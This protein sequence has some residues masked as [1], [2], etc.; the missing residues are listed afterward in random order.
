MQPEPTRTHTTPTPP[1]HR[2]H[3]E[4]HLAVRHRER[5]ESVHRAERDARA[6]RA[7]ADV[8]PDRHRDDRRSDARAD[9]VRVAHLRGAADVEAGPLLVAAG[10]R[11]IVTGGR[12]DRHRPL[13]TRRTGGRCACAPERVDRLQRP[14]GAPVGRRGSGMSD[15]DAEFEAAVSS[16][17][18]RTADPGNEAKLRLYAL[19]KQATV[20]DVSGRRP[21]IT[22]PVGRAKFDAWASVSGLSA[23]EAR[24]RYVEAVAA[25]ARRRPVSAAEILRPLVGATLGDDATVRVRC[26]DGS[27][28]GP[29]D[30]P[31]RWSSARGGPCAGCCG[32]PNELG[33]ARAYVAGDVDVEGD[34]FAG[35]DALDRLADPRAGPGVASTAARAAVAARGAAAG[36]RRAAAAR[37]RPRRC[38]GSPAGGTRRR[39]DAAA[40]AHHYD[41]GNDFYRLV[42]GPSHDLLLRLLGADRRASAWTTAQ[43]AKLDLVCRKLGLRAGHAAARRRLRL[44]HV[45]ASTPPALRRARRR[46]HA[47]ARAGRAAPASGSPRPG[48]PTGSRSGC[49]TTATCDD[50][51][52]DAIAQHRHGRARRR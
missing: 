4:L 44:G 30:A 47:V 34:I 33:F 41:V 12:T 42:L 3:A 13:L 37:R 5:T 49:R 45:R 22:H 27:A 17:T 29:S 40:I 10:V 7:D 24:R 9:Q 32:R 31:C 43:D 2:T 38:A 35:L 23:E 46:R 39:R 25:L 48:S 15:L 20:G 6:G 28:L 11:R 26:W 51:P 52:F 19:Y 16:V 1:D 50:G 14:G 8:G 18:A 21:G 36:R